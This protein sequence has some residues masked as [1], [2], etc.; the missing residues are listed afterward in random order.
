MPCSNNNCSNFTP[1][2]DGSGDVGV[3]PVGVQM[4][5]VVYPAWDQSEI[6]APDWER[7]RMMYYYNDVCETSY[8]IGGL[9]TVRGSTN[10]SVGAGNP[11]TEVEFGLSGVE[12]PNAGKVRSVL[13]TNYWWENRTD[14]CPTS[15]YGYG[16]WG[17]A[18]N[19]PNLKVRYWDWYPSEISF[20]PVSS[21]TWFS[22]MWDTTNGV[23]GRPCYVMCYFMY[24]RLST[25]SYGSGKTAYSTS[26]YNTYYGLRR[27]PFT[28]ACTPKETYV[29]YEIEDGKITEQED[30][31]PYPIIWSVGTKTQKIAFQYP[32][33]VVDSTVT[34]RLAGIETQKDVLTLGSWTQAYTSSGGYI[35]EVYTEYGKAEGFLKTNNTG[36]RYNTQLECRSGSTVVA[37]L[38]ATFRPA[39][40]LGDSGYPDSKVKITGIETTSN[41]PSITNGTTYDLYARYETNSKNQFKIGE[42]QFT[43]VA[44]S[45]TKKGVAITFHVNE[46]KQVTSGMIGSSLSSLGFYKVWDGSSGPTYQSPQ[47]N[48]VWESEN[49]NVI[50]DYTLPN[51]AVIRMRISSVKNGSNWYTN[52]KILRIIRRGSNYATGDGVTYTGQNTYYLYYPNADAANK[53]GI[54][55]MVSKTQDGNFSQGSTLLQVGDTIN[56]WTISRLKHSDD[57]FNTHVAELIKG[58]NSFTAD[59][60]YTSGIGIAVKVLAGWGIANRAMLIGRYEFQRKEIVYSTAQVDGDVPQEEYE[61]VKPKLQAV[62]EN[63]KITKVQIINPGRN[64]QDPRIEPIKIAV[65][66]PP[67]YVNHTKYVNNMESGDNPDI[68]WSKARGTG[69]L[70]KLQPVF[71]EGI[72]VDVKV[73]NGGSGYSSTKPPY[74]EVP[75]IAKEEVTSLESG[76]SVEKREG[77]GSKQLFEKSEAFKAMAKVDYKMGKLNLDVDDMTQYYTKN[78]TTGA[79]EFDSKKVPYT[80]YTQKG[81]TYSNYTSLQNQ[82]YAPKSYSKLKGS[83][84]DLNKKKNAQVYVAPKTGT[85]KSWAQQFLPPT[86]KEKNK[87]LSPDYKTLL[88]EMKKTDEKNKQATVTNKIS[89]ERSNDLK[90]LLSKNSVSYPNEFNIEPSKADLSYTGQNIKTDDLTIKSYESKSSSVKITTSTSNVQYY[91]QA[92]KDFYKDNLNPKDHKALLELMDSN[93]KTHEENINS[94]WKRDLDSA[95]TFVYDGV[96]TQTVKYAFYNLPCASADFKY[97]LN[98]FC[99]DPRPTTNIK[100]T[101]GV[102]VNNQDYTNERGPCKK[103]I[104]TDA[105]TISAYNSLVSSYGSGNVSM[106]DAWCQTYAFPTYYAAHTD[107]IPKGIPFGAYSLPYLSTIFGGYTRSYIKSQYGKQYVY[108]GCHDY[109][110]SGFLQVLHDL[111]LEGDIF[112]AALEKYGNPYDYKCGRVYEDGIAISQLDLNNTIGASE[113]YLPGAPNQ[114]SSPIVSEA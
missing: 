113:D 39:N 9:H 48:G 81:F 8:S 110:V 104:Y 71:S 42:V 80:E 44:R 15:F 32:G 33:G 41:T 58:T 66:Y 101:L 55:L 59:T 4:T 90:G 100:I 102:K 43:S 114:L 83:I 28:C 76:T 93:D 78:P 31:D 23:V 103:C 29:Y 1:T 70:A 57:E 88:S 2:G 60:T 84:K 34:I 64:L 40:G 18:A 61:I 49:T 108:E 47:G 45:N 107:G 20:E 53:V 94:L 62:V 105:A 52:W 16:G 13:G 51:G 3:S 24:T 111:T 6:N 50:K 38:N 5:K 27:V 12:N 69:K 79:F 89:N 112:T 96:S 36:H 21:D 26:R 22:Y 99:P 65:E 54:A 74:V 85:S 11:T 109:E 86:S 14:L 106:E 63:G 77:E 67:T 25:G 75:Y 68:A 97:M 72:L 95:R 17:A 37:K 98:G 7:D 91:P 30:P 19:R 46:P 10:D 87:E 82:H 92:F 35:A 73:I 56:G